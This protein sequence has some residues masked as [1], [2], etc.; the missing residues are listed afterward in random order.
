MDHIVIG[1]KQLSLGDSNEFE[2]EA[3]MSLSDRLKKFK[4]SQFDVDALISS[5]CPYMAEKVFSSH[6][7]F[8]I[9]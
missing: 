1:G 4:I 5:K 2:N 8:L 3:K 6:F 7:F 9:I